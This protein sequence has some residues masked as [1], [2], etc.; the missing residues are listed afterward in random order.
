MNKS[1]AIQNEYQA[2]NP[3]LINI[4]GKRL[5]H[6]IEEIRHAYR[7]KY[8]LIRENHGEKWR[9]IAVKK[10]SALFRGIISNNNGDF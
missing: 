10:L 5:P 3:S 8:N 2:L 9:Y 4:I 6:N 7:S 1:K